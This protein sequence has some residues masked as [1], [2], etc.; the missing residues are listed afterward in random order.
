MKT[1]STLHAAV[2]AGLCISFPVSALAEVA[3]VVSSKSS[4]G[5]LTVDE[6][7]NIFLGRA[8]TFPGG[9][10]A[11]P[12]DQAESSP[13]RE[14]FYSK[15]SGKTAAQLKAYW[16]KQIFTGKGRPPKEVADSQAVKQLISSNPN[17]VGYIDKSAVDA[18]V[19]VILNVK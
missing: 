4:A 15:T 8:S 6:A 11:V 10:N 3:V 16:S 14:E 7:A 17:M 9:E 12:L 5:A 19:K 1:I 2:L 18:S 13:L